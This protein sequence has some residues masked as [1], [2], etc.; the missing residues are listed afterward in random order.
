MYPIV[1]GYKDL[2]A[3]GLCLNIADPLGLHSLS[4]TASYSP[5]AFLPPDERFHASLEYR[6]WQWKLTSA[7][8]GA[9]FY[10]LFGPT[11]TSRKGY[12]AELSYTDY[13]LNDRPSLLE[14]SLSAAGYSGFEALPDYQNVAT[15]YDKFATLDGRLTYTRYLRSLGAVEYEE[16]FGWSL[17]TLNTFVHTSFYPQFYMTMDYGIMLP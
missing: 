13:L 16:G 2:V 17:H 14:Y 15:T 4:M 7:Y 11:K 5:Y 6:Y 10:D 1:E 12:A 8:N 3:Y 9:D